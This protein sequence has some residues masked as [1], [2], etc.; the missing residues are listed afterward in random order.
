M[1]VEN[2]VQSSP[3][4]PDEA[5]LTSEKSPRTVT[6]NDLATAIMKRVPQLSRRRALEI[7][8]CAL[9][10]IAEA[11]LERGESVK[12]HEF[13]TFCV[14][15]RTAGA[16]SAPLRAQGASA[17]RCR[18]VR[19]KASLRLKEKVERARA[20]AG[21]PTRDPMRSEA[22]LGPGRSHNA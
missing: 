6:R 7:V 9:H 16:A 14:R 19:F 17:H 8:D 4:R 3:S 12:L 15:E 21:A 11:L 22:A 1:C 20:R 18:V 13:G 2:F 5:S 10:E